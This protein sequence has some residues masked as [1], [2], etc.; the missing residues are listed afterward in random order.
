M[1]EPISDAQMGFMR[2]L[3]DL[4]EGTV[5]DVLAGL[6]KDGKTLA[7]TTVATVLRRLESKGWVEHREEGRGFVYRAAVSREAATG[8]L[9]ERLAGSL[10]GGNIPDLVSHLIDSRDVSKRDLDRIKSL[11]EAKE[12]QRRAR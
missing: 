5:S 6:E 9:V 8:S 2:V 4:G 10:F 7:P 3:W 11:I 12:R 1:P